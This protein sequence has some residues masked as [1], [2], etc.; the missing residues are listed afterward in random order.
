MTTCN[1]SVVECF[2]TVFGAPNN[3]LRPGSRSKEIIGGL[4]WP[5]SPPRARSQQIAGTRLS[6]FRARAEVRFLVPCIEWRFGRIF[7][8]KLQGLRIGV[9]AQFGDE[10]QTEIRP[11]CDSDTWNTIAVDNDARLTTSA[12]GLLRGLRA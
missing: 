7:G 6:P 2:E 10:S 8:K 12:T 9:V 1:L 11:G 3:W 4:T 5:C